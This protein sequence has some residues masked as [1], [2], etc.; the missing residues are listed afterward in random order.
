MALPDEFLDHD[1]PAA[2]YARA[3]LD[4]SAVVRKALE[5][6]GRRERPK[7]VKR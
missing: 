7:I 1:S 6:L 3:G 4:A 2:Q 5:A